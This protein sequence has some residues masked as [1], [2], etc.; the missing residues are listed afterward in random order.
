MVTATSFREAMEVTTDLQGNYYKR[1]EPGYRRQKE[2]YLIPVAKIVRIVQQGL[3][4]KLYGDL[5]SVQ[6][7][8]DNW[9]LYFNN[10]RS[11]QDEMCCGRK[12][13]KRDEHHRPHRCFNPCVSF[14]MVII[15]LPPGSLAALQHYQ[16]Q[17]TAWHQQHPIETAMAFFFIYVVITTLSIP[18]G[19]LLTL[20]AGSQFG[21]IKGTLLVLLAATCGAMLA[22][23]ITNVLN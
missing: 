1:C 4:K 12:P 9:L 14:A 7:D 20:L 3:R 23:L 5:G 15:F 21:L 17:F 18:C 19:T 2:R 22:M 8:L 13:G 6:A 11:H 10:E 16:V